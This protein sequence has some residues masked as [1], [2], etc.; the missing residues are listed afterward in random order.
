VTTT[1]G[2]YANPA[3]NAWGNRTRFQNIWQDRDTQ[4]GVDIAS[5][6]V[7]LAPDQTYFWR[8]RYRDEHFDWSEWSEEVSFATAPV[9]PWSPAAIGGAK[10]GLPSTIVNVLLL[11][12]P[13]AALLLWKRS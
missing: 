6:P 8:V 5:Y 10:P 1:A 12:V 3:V 7:N 11:F 4:A 13:A 9:T 2:D